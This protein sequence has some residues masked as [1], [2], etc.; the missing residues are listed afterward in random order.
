V[1]VA[2]AEVTTRIDGT[3]TKLRYALTFESAGRGPGAPSSLWVKGGFDPKGANQ[4]EA[5]ANE[6]NFFRD[7]APRLAIVKPDSYYG[8][9]DAVTRNGVVLLE[10]LISRGV[11]FGDSSRPLTPDQ[12]AAVL[13]LQARYHAA[14]WRSARLD[15]FP[16]LKAGG[17]IAGADMVD[18]FFGLWEGSVTL[19]RFRH[20]PPAQRDKPRVKAALQRLMLDLR[21]QPICLVHGDSHAANL[22]FDLVEGPGYLD[23]QHTMRGHWAFDLAGFL[24]TAL[25]VDDRRA[26]E[27]TLLTHYLNE[28]GAHGASAPSF[29]EAWEAYRRYVMWTFM[30]AMCPPE[31]HPEAI[32][33]LNTERACAAIEDLG[34]LECLE[35]M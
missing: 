7:L 2:T 14:F 29:D 3:A 28:L 21:T 30:W 20:V 32:C 35:G 11:T 25:T 9:I 1:R 15:D 23:W 12:A 17:A 6:V 10:D 19:P 27:R 26:S 16:W 18:Q 33:R 31:A 22:F 5:F 24:V 13:S 4:G 34:T 8:A